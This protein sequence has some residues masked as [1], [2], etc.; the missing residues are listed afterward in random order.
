VRNKE[1]KGTYGYVDDIDDVG[2]CGYET[3][4]VVESNEC[5]VGT[6]NQKSQMRR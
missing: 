4:V 1:R 3:L 2:F 5:Y 6:C